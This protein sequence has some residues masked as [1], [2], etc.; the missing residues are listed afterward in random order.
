MRSKITQLPEWA[1]YLLSRLSN[2]QVQAGLNIPTPRTKAIP[3]APYRKIHLV[4]RKI[5]GTGI[6]ASTINKIRINKR[7]GPKSLEKLKDLYKRYNYAKLRAAGD[8]KDEAKLRRNDKPS[9]VEW[10]LSMLDRF[11]DAVAKD[12][13]VSKEAI[14]WGFSKSH[15]LL[16]DWQNLQSGGVRFEE[17]WEEFDQRRW[18]EVSYS[19]IKVR[20]P[21]KM[22]PAWMKYVFERLNIKELQG[23]ISFTIRGKKYDIKGCG[24][25]K[26][27]LKII[28]D[29]ADLTRSEMKSLSK[30]YMQYA[31]IELRAAG[32]SSKEANK[33]NLHSI[34]RLQDWIKKKKR[35]IQ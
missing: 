8:R 27:R 10:R 23:G 7:I 31:R 19:K 22:L 13:K 24:I 16:T 1:S 2:G 32:Y 21:K 11:V 26:E 15:K 3:T 17:L 5:K 4:D 18:K 9:Q 14:S 6:P 30:T 28:Q 35:S 25:S 34:P 20:Q 29:T 33:F 12:K